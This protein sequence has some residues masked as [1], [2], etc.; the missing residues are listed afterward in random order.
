M[1]VLNGPGEGTWSVLAEK[2]VRERDEAREMLFQ[3]RQECARAREQRDIAL[4]ALAVAEREL[5][6]RD[7]M[8]A[9]LKFQQPEATAVDSSDGGAARHFRNCGPL[10]DHV[11]FCADCEGTY[12]LC[13]KHESDPDSSVMWKD[14]SDESSRSVR[15]R[16]P[17]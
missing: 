8:L 9:S 1:S 3:A 16:L 13:P 2:A 17:R 12:G 5:A 11:V 15:A 7:E 6:L 14:K 4:A 10:C